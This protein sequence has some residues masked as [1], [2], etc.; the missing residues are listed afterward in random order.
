MTKYSVNRQ[1][2]QV[3]E[4][5]VGFLYLL[6]TIYLNFIRLAEEIALYIKV[7]HIWTH[8]YV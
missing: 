4:L 6:H 3:F 8:M 5:Q 2:N 7:T 1:F